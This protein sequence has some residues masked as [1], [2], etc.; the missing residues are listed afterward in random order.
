[1]KI[2][3][4]V[5]ILT[6]EFS[7]AANP[8]M[9]Q[10]QSRQ[11]EQQW[12]WQQQQSYQQVQQ[13]Q[14]QAQLREQQWRWQQQQSYR[15]VQQR[16]RQAQQRE[17][18]WRWGQ[19]H[20]CHQVQPRQ[21]Q[22][23][24]QGQQQW[25]LAPIVAPSTG[26]RTNST[27]ESDRRQRHQMLESTFVT[28]VTP[29]TSTTG[30]T[31]SIFE[32]DRRQRYQMLESTFVTNVTPSTTTTTSSA[33]TAASGINSVSDAIFKA[34]M[35]ERDFILKSTMGAETKNE[36]WEYH[37]MASQAWKEGNY[38]R[39][40]S[41]VEG[42]I[43]TN[44]L[45]INLAS[46]YVSLAMLQW[47]QNYKASAKAS[48]R[49]AIEVMRTGKYIGNSSC[50]ERA[51]I[52]LKKMENDELPKSFNSDDTNSYGVLGYIMEA[53]RAAYNKKIQE[54]NHR[55]DVLAL[56]ASSMSKSYRMQGESQARWAKLSARAEYQK[57][58]GK[59][60]SPDAP[61][62]SGS[63]SREAWDSCKKVYDIFK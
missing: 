30:S 47:N 41:A 8:W 21:Q 14:R 25:V 63:S 34:D 40:I 61:P 28:N 6:A 16:Q 13:R 42:M 9:R 48:M 24:R 59:T 53:P 1:M 51:V 38:I 33:S 50:E 62:P 19:Q 32:S 35:K 12:R 49:K 57:A 55:S 36:Y 3:Y 43:K 31:N 4:C 58:T 29:S 52:F 45:D 22:P 23:L 2:L 60:F 10:Q 26:S 18:Q 5:M 20:S 7:L 17:Q 56:Y 54:L 46:D 27:F 39:A 15:Q 37:K 44:S 11:R